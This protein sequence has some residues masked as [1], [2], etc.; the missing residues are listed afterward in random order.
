MYSGGAEPIPRSSFS[1]P[2]CSLVN[3][4]TSYT[5]QDRQGGHKEGG[6]DK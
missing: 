4:V 6:T 5:L 2:G 3:A 1:P